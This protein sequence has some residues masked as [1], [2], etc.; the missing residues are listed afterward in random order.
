VPWSYSAGPNLKPQRT[1]PPRASPS[2]TDIP[3]ERWSATIFSMINIV[4]YL[5][6]VL[7]SS[8]DVQITSAVE[9]DESFSALSIMIAINAKMIQAEQKGNMTRNN[10]CVQYMDIRTCAATK[11]T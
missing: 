6:A 5:Y 9:R 10:G 11:F 2:A 4:Q 1:F 7:N 3:Q 8:G